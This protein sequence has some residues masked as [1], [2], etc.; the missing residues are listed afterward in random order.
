LFRFLFLDDSQTITESHS[1]VLHSGEDKNE[2][3]KILEKMFVNTSATNSKYNEISIIDMIK[4][5]IP[6]KL[7]IESNNVITLTEALYV[8]LLSEKLG[9]S[10]K[11]IQY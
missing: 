11:H 3:K 5:A 7:N 10:R 8:K 1:A 6:S 9:K 2:I 4:E